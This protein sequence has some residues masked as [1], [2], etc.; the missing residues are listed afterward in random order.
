MSEQPLNIVIVGGGTAGWMTANLLA[1]RW[2]HK[3]VKITLVESPD[4]GIIGVGEGSTP[5][6][7]RFF[8]D[9]QIA[10]SDW[11]PACNATYKV[12]IRFDGW[13]PESGVNSYAHP[14]IGQLDTFSERAFYV[15]CMT[16]RL[17]LDVN[18]KPEDFL[19][20]GWLAN[21]YRSPKTPANFPF[22]IEYGYHFDS[23]LLGGFLQRYAQTQGVTHKALKITGVKYHPS[24]DIKELHTAEGQTIQGDV[25]IDCSGFR[26]LLL[27]QTLKVPFQSFG[28]NLFN[29]SAVVCATAP[30]TPL[31]VETRSTALSAGW[32]WQIPLTNRT[33]NGYVYSSAYLDPEQ[34]EA[35]LCKHLGLNR[36]NTQIRHLKMNVGQVSEHWFKNCVAV[37]LA[38]GFIEPLEATAL[39]LVQT[40]VEIFMDH[41]EKGGFSDQ[42]RHAY[43]AVIRERFER[44]RDYIVAHYKLNTRNDSE[45]WRANRNNEA[46]SESLLQLLDVWFR[47]GDLQ[48]EIQR[49]K[50]DSHFGATSW[51]CLLAGYGAFPR[52]AANQPNTGDLYKEH[53]LETFFSG[54]LLNF[55][56]Q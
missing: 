6:L 55:A 35:E 42:Y 33:G 56:A 14:F 31:P 40:S 5:T 43:N 50:L 28:N 48:Q 20:N 47:R 2:Q 22:R 19:F 18:V 21:Y 54:C 15:N 17:G 44:V 11:M 3:A 46:L 23:G 13:S 12:S 32:A 41:Y 49:Q 38:Q 24:G 16:R 26:S 30:L 52:L 8:D 25:F 1:K 29:D 53:N 51:H 27:Q 34:A 45:Y 36:E 9:M 10:E 4:I 37:G 7:K 39:H